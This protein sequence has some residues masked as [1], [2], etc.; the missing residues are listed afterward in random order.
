MDVWSR[1]TEQCYMC[2]VHPVIK[3]ST[4]PSYT[5]D[6]DT[7]SIVEVLSTSYPRETGL[8]LW[9]LLLGSSFPSFI[10]KGDV[11][12]NFY[13]LFYLLHFKSYPPLP[14]FSS[15]NLLSHPL[16][17]L[18][19]GCYPTHPST[20]SHLILTGLQKSRRKK[21]EWVGSYIFPLLILSR[22]DGIWKGQGQNGSQ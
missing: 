1:V 12:N 20:H 2:N 15:P 18:L 5:L 14:S 11:F 6:T 4:G 13:W 8:G 22:I 3:H 9:S 10:C 7:L 19:W 16:Y 21:V 17:L